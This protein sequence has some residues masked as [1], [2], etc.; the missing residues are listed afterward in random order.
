MQIDR[1]VTF[2]CSLTYGHGLED[3]IVNGKDPGP[4]PSK[5]AWPAVVGEKLNLL[6]DNQG[7][8]GAS[9][10]QILHTILNYKFNP[11]DLVIIMW[12]HTDRDFIF[13]EKGI[14]NRKVTPVAVGIW[15]DTEL[16]KNW[17]LAHS[18]VDNAIK[19]WLHIHHANLYLQLKDIKTCN[20]FADNRILKK[21][22]PD[23]IN[24]NIAD[25]EVDR[26]RRIYPLALDN[27][28]PGKECHIE[29]ANRILT[30]I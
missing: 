26:I 30:N 13:K 16:A 17:I 29:I 8:P 18:E 11:T 7:I 15:Q 27:S 3:C 10:L 23:Y 19:S 2:G 12:S 5:Q 21:Y 24:L 4:N 20:F 9:N 14:I 28:H 6:V 22:K 1:L 25:I